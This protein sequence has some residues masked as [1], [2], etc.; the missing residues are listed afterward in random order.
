MHRRL[1]L[2]LAAALFSFTTAASAASKPTGKSAAKPAAK[3][4][5][6]SQTEKIAAPDQLQEF[7]LARKL[8]DTLGFGEGLPEKPVEKDYLQILAGGRTFKF[9]AEET[10][11]RQSD[12]AVVRNYPLFGGFSGSGWVHGSTNRVAVHFKVFIPVSGR[13]T[14]RVTAK[15]DDQLWSLAGKA[16]KLNSGERFSESTFAQVFIPAG[17]LEFNAVIPPAG[18]IDC[19]SFTAPAYA[20]VE[21]L[22]GWNPTKPLTAAAVNETVAAL[23]GLE[24]L[25]P[26]DKDYPPRTIEAASL[27]ALPATVQTTDTQVRG[28]S[29]AAQWVR[30]YQ[31]GATLA[32]P[33]DIGVPSVY[34]IRVRAVGTVISAGFGQRRVT[35][36]L[37]PSLDW[38]DLGTFRLPKGM[39]TLELQLPPTGGI[40]LIEVTKKITSPAAYAA[41]TKTGIEDNA[42]IKPA[43]LDALI[44]SLKDRF[45]ERR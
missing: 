38:T 36:E 31:T 18:A 4:A 10:F 12:Q 19:F 17:E 44:R 37:H 42:P 22:A 15:G 2:M 8:V 33:L 35:A 30:A 21:P 40:D 43:E 9:E 23:L 11:D 20:P 3:T 28:K 32:V 34:R 26:E 5:V 39:N 16:F 14:F 1:F 45:K 24:T 41:I 29:V 13:Y 27:P 6:T 25:L 7:E